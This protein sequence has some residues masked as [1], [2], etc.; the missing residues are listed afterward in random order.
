MKVEFSLALRAS[1]TDFNSVPQRPVNATTHSPPQ[2]LKPTPSPAYS[3]KYTTQ[4]YGQ[5]S[6]SLKK[7][8]LTCSLPLMPTVVLINSSTPSLTLSEKVLPLSEQEW[9]VVQS[10]NFHCTTQT[11]KS[12]KPASNLPSGSAE[13]S[14]LPSTGPS[15]QQLFFT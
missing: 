13:H 5:I 7:I 15:E 3:V 4:P 9:P 1:P 10:S 2:F 8:K 6:S 11:G 12:H 14:R